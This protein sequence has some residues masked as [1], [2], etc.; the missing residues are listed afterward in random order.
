MVTKSLYIYM[1]KIALKLCKTLKIVTYYYT[2]QSTF[3]TV[4]SIDIDLLVAAINIL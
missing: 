4:H 1:V 2:L 3:V